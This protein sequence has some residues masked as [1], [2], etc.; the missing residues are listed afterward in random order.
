[1]GEAAN[2]TK[3]W[4][5]GHKEGGRLAVQDRKEMRRWTYKKGMECNG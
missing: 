2:Q 3:G 5:P 4:H 1:M